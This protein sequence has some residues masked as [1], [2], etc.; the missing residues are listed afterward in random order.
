MVDTRTTAGAAISVSDSPCWF[1]AHHVGGVLFSGIARR[2]QRTLFCSRCLCGHVLSGHV[3]TLEHWNLNQGPEMVSFLFC[4]FKSLS[5]KHAHT[6]RQPGICNSYRA[7]R[8]MSPKTTQ[9]GPVERENQ[10]IQ[11]PGS[12]AKV[13]WTS[14]CSF[15]IYAQKGDSSD[16]SYLIFTLGYSVCFALPS[17]Q[18]FNLPRSSGRQPQSLDSQTRTRDS[19]RRDVSRSVSI[20]SMDG[21]S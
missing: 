4:L 18:G 12:W 13:D 6:R 10:M 8:S 17:A 11:F 3:S 19:R 14:A 15:T 9:I 16:S 2:S 20:P 1:D 5:S 21:T 7:S